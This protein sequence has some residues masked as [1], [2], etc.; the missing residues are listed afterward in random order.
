M[1]ASAAAVAT[2]P[3]SGT[4]S[5]IEARVKRSRIKYRHEVVVVGNAPSADQGRTIT[6]QF[7]PG[8]TGAWQ[9]I[10][11]ARIGSGGS[12]RLAASLSRSG[13]V[14]ATMPAP[15]TAAR[16][17]LLGALGSST[18]TPLRVAVAAAFHLRPRAFNVLGARTIRVRGRLV[19]DAARRLVMLQGDRSGR[20]V[21]L[22]WD[23]SSDRGVFTLRYRAHRLGQ[24]RLRVAFTGDRANTAAFSHAGSLT[25]FR[26][27]VASWYDD[28]GTTACGFHAYHGV[29]NLSLP[30]GTKVSFAYRGRTVEAVVDDR[31]PYVAGR[32][33]DLNQNTAS[34]LGMVGVATVWAS[35]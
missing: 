16:S 5:T 6:L 31:G 8:E 20:W 13:W 11:T 1:P 3:Q 24:E 34:A 30:C 35:R 17:T 29:A 25:V 21:T 7:E 23:R 28:A 32:T 15:A 26:Q 2:S 9:Q 18:S 27:A 4:G 22:S 10:A 33:W 12:F 14:R 19:P